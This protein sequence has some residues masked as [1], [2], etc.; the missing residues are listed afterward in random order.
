MVNQ[1][2][3]PI[4]EIASVPTKKPISRATPG[5]GKQRYPAP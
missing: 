3:L 2:L 1:D 5:E 4:L